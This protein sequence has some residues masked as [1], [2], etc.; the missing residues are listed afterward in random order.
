MVEVELRTGS[1]GCPGAG[2]RDVAQ[3][4]E[5]GLRHQRN[6]SSF[7]SFDFG[8]QITTVPA[9]ASVQ[10]CTVSVELDE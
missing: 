6:L 2:S 8:D 5:K 10:H 4:Q 7:A 3:R 9:G 1:E